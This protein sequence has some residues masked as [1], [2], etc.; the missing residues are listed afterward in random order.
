MPKIWH[1]LSLRVV[2]GP[3]SLS[4]FWRTSGEGRAGVGRAQL[5]IG[6]M[7]FGNLVLR[8][9][10]SVT[11]RAI[12]STSLP[13]LSSVRNEQCYLLCGAVIK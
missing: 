6:Q 11:F 2:H 1:R 3:H 9:Y 4:A 8:A 5:G 13:I 7:R 12:H 10:N